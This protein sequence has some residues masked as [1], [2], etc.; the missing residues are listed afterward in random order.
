MVYKNGDLAMKKI[1]KIFYWIFVVFIIYL[2][3]EVIRKIFG[4]SL[5]FEEL[6]SSLVLANIGYSFY[7]TSEINSKISEMNAKL[8]EH[9]GWHKGKSENN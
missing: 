3:I 1:G 9:V 5:G 2:I 6:I 8:S 4:G 7:I